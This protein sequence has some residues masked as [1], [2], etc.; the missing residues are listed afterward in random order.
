MKKIVLFLA[1]VAFLATSCAEKEEFTIKGKFANTEYDGKQVYLQTLDSLW[2]KPVNIDTATVLNGVFEFKGLAKEGA[3]AHFVA[4]A[5]PTEMVKRPIFVVVEPGVIEL[6]LDSVS[7]VK[8]TK[9]N[10][11][12]QVYNS[13]IEAIGN[14]MKALYQEA[15]K[16]TANTE[17]QAQLEKQYEEKNDQM[18]QETFDF[19]KSNVNTQWGTY[20]FASKSYIFSVDQLKELLA[21][22]RPEEKGLERIAALEKRVAA[23]DATAEGKMFVDVKGKTPEGA[24]AALSD[25]AGKGKYVLVD[26]WASWCGPCRAEMP[27]IVKAYNT[28]KDKGFEI[29]GLSLDRD[30]EAWKKGITALNIT[31]PQISDLKF[32]DSELSAAYGISSIPHTVLLDKDGKILARGLHGKELA[33]KLAELMK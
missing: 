8:G 22:V 9:S 21:K 30:G 14:E 2:K 33:D 28:Y 12:Y 11:A 24:D 16:D 13:K 17:L 27:N 25:Y 10:D 29:V 19:L 6:N 7:T 18:T 5:E 31:W 20:L 1:A 23:L 3:T 26:F 4:L 15:M 32:W